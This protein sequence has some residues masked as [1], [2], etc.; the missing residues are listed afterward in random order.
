MP[1][2]LTLA[3]QE[4][5]DRCTVPHDDPAL[6]P[7][8]EKRLAQI[9]ENW[10]AVV[11]DLVGQ[12]AFKSNDDKRH[13]LHTGGLSALEDAFAALGWEDPHYVEEGGCEHPG[14]ARWATCGTPTPD[15]Y[16]RLCGEHYR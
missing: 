13:W 16:R 1:V 4:E 6:P 2:D 15:G 11:E 7:P 8:C 9:R 12:F 5:T 10:R 3:G 14:C